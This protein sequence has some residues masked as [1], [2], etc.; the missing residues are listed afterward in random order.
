MLILKL[1]IW[2]RFGVYLYVI[3][4]K[5]IQLSLEIF[6]EDG[7]P[8]QIYFVC[9]LIMSHFLSPPSVSVRRM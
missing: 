8:M 9:H 1:L 4:T 6:I 3:N 7:L 2:L 5:P